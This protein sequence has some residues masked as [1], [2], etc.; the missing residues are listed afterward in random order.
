MSSKSG[1]N[2]SSTF[3]LYVCNCVDD[4]VVALGLSV[5]DFPRYHVPNVGRSPK[6]QALVGCLMRPLTRVVD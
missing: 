6:R 1:G 3:H 5:A 2:C 4:T